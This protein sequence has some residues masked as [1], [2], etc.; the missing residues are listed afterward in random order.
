MFHY[1]SGFQVAINTSWRVLV[2]ISHI[3]QLYL[4]QSRL[5]AGRLGFGGGTWQEV[6]KIPTKKPQT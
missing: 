6:S 2:T 5:G 3:N 4:P 1:F